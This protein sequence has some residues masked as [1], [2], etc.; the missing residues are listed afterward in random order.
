MTL[1]PIAVNAGDADIETD[2][3]APLYRHVAFTPK[4]EK[5]IIK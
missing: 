2:K 4:N 1:G 5:I 3:F